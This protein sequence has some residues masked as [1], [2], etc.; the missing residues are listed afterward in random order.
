MAVYKKLLEIQAAVKG[1]AKDKKAFNYE[2]V[3][4]DKVLG[5]IRPLMS[6]K[7]LL[8]LPSVTDVKTEVIQYEAYDK[9]A[10]GLVAKTEILY[11]VSMDMTWVDS[12][13]GDSVTEKWAGS[14]MNAFDKGFGSALT[15][16]ERYY[17]L[18]TFHI[19]TDKDDVD[20]LATERDEA[21]EKGYEAKV[22]GAYARPIM[23][24]AVEHTQQ[25]VATEEKKKGRI[26]I[27]GKAWHSAVEKHAK[28]EDMTGA[29]EERYTM[30]ESDWDSFFSAVNIFKKEN[31]I[32]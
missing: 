18:K 8:L 24:P 20:A 30:T 12:T 32:A 7:G 17:L 29:I 28:G 6:E 25:P 13:D 27:G 2:Y 1:L 10:K 4:G 16:G 15:Y 21:L 19:P 9:V 31:N 11:V 23:Q 22:Q 26:L 3:T 14:G 5:F